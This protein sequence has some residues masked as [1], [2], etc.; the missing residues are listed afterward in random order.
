MTRTLPRTGSAAPTGLTL[1]TFF[2]SKWQNHS[3]G[4]STID[5]GTFTATLARVAGAGARSKAR[6]LV[7]RTRTG[8]DAVPPEDLKVTPHTRAEI[9]LTA[10]HLAALP[11]DVVKIWNTALY[12][13]KCE[14]EEAGWTARHGS[15]RW[16]RWRAVQRSLDARSPHGKHLRTYT[17]HDT[18]GALEI[19]VEI[20]H[21]STNDSGRAWTLTGRGPL[22]EDPKY[23]GEIT[24]PHLTDLH[25]KTTSSDGT[26]DHT[27][28]FD[29]DDDDWG[30]RFA[31]SLTRAA[32][33]L[34]YQRLMTEHATPGR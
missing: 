32:A 19:V 31:E 25:L 8:T 24:I 33:K 28:D 23:A 12:R 17:T 29:G 3:D 2:H 14:R 4:S 27:Y 26:G 15:E 21:P 10:L 34:T 16:Q 11:T 13:V 30:T 9:I 20:D 7:V 6:N 5:T 18:Q 1:P 22:T